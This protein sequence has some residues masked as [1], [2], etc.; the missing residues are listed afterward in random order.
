M[1]LFFALS[2]TLILFILGVTI[3][4]FIVGPTI[5]LQPRK[6]TAEFYRKLG[7]PVLPSEVDLPC[8]EIDVITDGGVKL[9]CWLIKASPPTRGTVIYLH[10]VADA[11]IDG[12]RFAKLMHDNSFNIFLYDARRH[13]NSDGTFCTY[14]YFEKH[15][16]T[17]IID[18][19]TSRA[20]LVLGK[21]GLFGTSMGA[22]VAL[23]AA[24]IDKRIAAVIAENSFATLRS[25]FDD[26]QKR[27]IQLPFHYLRNLVIK[28]SELMA[29][30]KA[31]DVSPLDA[32]RDIHIPLLFI[33]ASNDQ[34]IKYQYSIMLYEQAN[35]PKELFPIENAMHHDTWNVAG[36]VYEKKLVEFFGKNLQ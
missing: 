11:K 10:G 15:D 12:I 16:V 29:N 31:N 6:R 32:V 4:L 20:D 8:E 5:L 21:I 36:K 24:S 28:R 19:L 30:F 33:Y 35:V 17:R 25:I 14:G 13:G 18:Y 2:A 27:L 9:N 7:Q 34:L 23:Q 26:Y 22:A 3:I 1:T